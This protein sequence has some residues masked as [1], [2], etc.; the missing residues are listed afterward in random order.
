[1]MIVELTMIVGVDD[2]SRVD[3]DDSRVDD[4]DSRVDDDSRCRR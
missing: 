2:D 4:D 3:D 1:M